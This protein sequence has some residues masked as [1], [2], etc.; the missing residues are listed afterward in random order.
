[1]LPFMNMYQPDVSVRRLEETVMQNLV[2]QSTPEFEQLVRETQVSEHIAR[3]HYALIASF[4]A[5]LLV[6]VVY[7]RV[8]QPLWVLYLWFFAVSTLS[9]LRLVV[10]SRSWRHDAQRLGRVGTWEKRIAILAGL[11]GFA[12]GS[13]GL[14]SVFAEPAYRILAPL[15]IVGV[16]SGGFF[17]LAEQPKAFAAFN[18]CMLLPNVVMYALREQTVEHWMAFTLACFTA[19]IIIAGRLTARSLSQSTELRMRLAIALDEAEAS[20]RVAENANQAKSQFLANMSHELRTP[21][22]AILSFSQLGSNKTDDRKLAS[23]FERIQTSGDR[24]LALINDLLD[25]SKFETGRMEIK[26]EEQPVRPLVDSAVQE[27]EGLLG[28]YGIQAKIEEHGATKA[29]VDGLRF[30]QVIRNLLSNAMKFS[31][32]GGEIRVKLMQL[33]N[34]LRMEIADNG[35]GIPEND[36]EAIFDEFVLGNPTSPKHRGTGLGLAICRRIVLAHKGRIFARNCLCGAEIVVE[37]PN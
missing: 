14:L 9:I 24:L 12:W 19:A 31:P 21:M 5:A 34:L 37:I 29:C 18:L 17:S 36:I 28:Q 3:T 27:I 35:T 33:P 32:P 8:F 13:I 16:I 2:K 1:M 26:C 6:V 4:V 30:G 25:L 15:F 22:H 7:Q 20:R 10:L 11:S 23:Y